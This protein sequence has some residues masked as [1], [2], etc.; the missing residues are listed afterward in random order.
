MANEQQ[1]HVANIV[2][3][4]YREL[5]IRINRGD[6]VNIAMKFIAACADAGLLHIQA[7]ESLIK[8]LLTFHAKAIEED[9]ENDYFL[10]LA[11]IGYIFGRRLIRENVDPDS[12]PEI[13]EV[14][15][16]FLETRPKTANDYYIF[17]S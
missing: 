1:E 4:I 6:D 9:K 13:E 2:Y 15:E 16:N 10:H 14:I 12:K 7:F 8:Q 17:K 11:I 3:E 5:V